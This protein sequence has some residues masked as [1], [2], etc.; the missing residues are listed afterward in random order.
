MARGNSLEAVTLA[1]A[2]IK[3]LFRHFSRSVKIVGFISFFV[4]L[5]FGMVLF[6]IIVNGDDK[7]YGSLYI[8]SELVNYLPI[9]T[10][11]RIKMISKSGEK[12]NILASVLIKNKIIKNHLDNALNTIFYVMISMVFFWVIIFILSMH[13]MYKYGVNIEKGKHV[14]GGKKTENKNLIKMLENDDNQSDIKFGDVPIVRNSETQHIFVSGGTGTGKSEALK[15]TLDTIRNKRDEK[16]II[17]DKSG[18]FTNRYYREG[19]DIIMNPFDNRMPDWSL[20]NEIERGY[21]AENIA[22]SFIPSSEEGS[23]NKHWDDSARAVLADFL[24]VTMK[25]DRIMNKGFLDIA[26]RSTLKEKYDLLGG[27]DSQN[28]LDPDQINHAM[29]VVDSYTN[30]IRS[31][32]YIKDVP[33]NTGF[34]LR[35]WVRN[36][37]DKRCVFVVTNGRQLDTVRPLLTAWIDIV[38][39]EILSLSPDKSRRIWLPVDEMASLDK[40]DSLL[41]FVN[42]ARKFGGCGLFSI[43]S[44]NELYR[45][46]GKESAH[47]FIAMCATKLTYRCDEP[48]TAS[49]LSDLY[50]KEDIEEMRDGIQVSENSRGDVMN[51]SE[52]RSERHL[53]T[54]SEIS[55]LDD[56]NALLKIKGNYPVTKIA[57]DK[58]DDESENSLP[59]IESIYSNHKVTSKDAVSTYNEKKITQTKRKKVNDIEEPEGLFDSCGPKD[60]K[61]DLFL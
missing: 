59:Y 42:E 41:T 37:K 38:I 46:Y 10:N 60:N 54:A 56:F 40:I 20:W 49:W 18:E 1:V 34:S 4:S 23:S 50:N 2:K 33:K 15:L 58:V 16:F 45:I 22:Q 53:F 24:N 29:S 5:V 43:T 32:K 13:Y 17:Y 31:L 3:T 52:Q 61:E 11:K 39:K 9:I 48:N 28:L 7:Y 25:D 26:L 30:R 14:R 8:K 47:T 12:R 44:I 55:N 36:E 19:F 21:D 57:L 6:F 27:L 35:K 51:L